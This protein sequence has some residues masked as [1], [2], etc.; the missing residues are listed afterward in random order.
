[1]NNKID[2]TNIVIE[3]QTK[4]TPC[5]VAM[6]LNLTEINI[7]VANTV[8]LPIILVKRTMVQS[9]GANSI[10]WDRYKIPLNL[11][12]GPVHWCAQ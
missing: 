6:D 1:M 7:Q 9:A 11:N 5:P 3:N 8:P 12:N 2:E 10:C 4:V